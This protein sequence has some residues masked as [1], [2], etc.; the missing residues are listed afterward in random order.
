V[1]ESASV[2]KTVKEL[3]MAAQQYTG[4]LV[5]RLMDG[6]DLAIMDLTG[7]SDPYCVFILGTQKT[8]S[9]TVQKSLN[10]VWNENIML[11]CSLKD[12]LEVQLYDEDTISKG[13]YTKD[14][15]YYIR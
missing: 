5:V 7:S 12:T 8:K 15:M 14:R 2:S 9:K 4:V 6:K 3:Q 1:T 13:T 11:H 10:P